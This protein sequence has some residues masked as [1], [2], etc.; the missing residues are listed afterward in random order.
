M[1]KINFQ[2]TIIPDINLINAEY[3]N[4][5]FKR[6]F[7]LDYH[8]GLLTQGE[9]KFYYQGNKYNTGPGQLQIMPAG[10]GT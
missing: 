6:H 9:Q 10:C 4:F 5:S 1:N 2:Q 7:H 3:K 8:F